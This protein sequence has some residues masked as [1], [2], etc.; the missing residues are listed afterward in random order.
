MDNVRLLKISKRLIVKPIKNS[1]RKSSAEIKPREERLKLC[2]IG[3][4]V[5]CAVCDLY[6]QL[7]ICHV[8]QQSVKSYAHLSCHNLLALQLKIVLKKTARQE[9][10]RGA[11]EEDLL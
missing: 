9:D 1:Q 3:V 4:V 7:K 11:A 8:G 10:L 6:E 5:S 2:K